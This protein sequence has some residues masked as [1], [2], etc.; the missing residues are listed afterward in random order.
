MTMRMR[1]HLLALAGF[2]GAW[3]A[4]WAGPAA[5]QSRPGGPEAV[6]AQAL[7]Q[8]QLDAFKA[9]NADLAFSYATPGIQAQF[10]SADT[11]LR[12]VREQYPVVYRP[13]SVR[14]DPLEGSGSDRILP[15]RLT[16][17]EGR[18]WIAYY[19]MQRQDNG[20][21]RIGGC[22]LKLDGRSQSI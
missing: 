5:A 14:F 19:L 8:A 9:D 21:W 16:D 1:L 17:D 20:I 6:A 2:V 12:M 18:Q 15:V 4:L 22:Q 13:A 11:F 10:G 7:V 3:V